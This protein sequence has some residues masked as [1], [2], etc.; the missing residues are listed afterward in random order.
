MSKMAG[1]S[2]AGV[3]TA[4]Y[5][6][7]IHNREY[8]HKQHNRNHNAGNP[9]PGQTPHEATCQFLWD[10]HRKGTYGLHFRKSNHLDDGNMITACW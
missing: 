3:R 10:T 1:G 9:S 2:A 4:A 6:I 8:K 5:N 7:I